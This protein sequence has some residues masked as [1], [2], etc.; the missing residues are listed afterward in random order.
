MITTAATQGRYALVG[1]AGGVSVVDLGA[2][3][4]PELIGDV[5]L[6]ASPIE[7]GATGNTVAARWFFQEFHACGA[8][9][10]I[11]DISNPTQPS[12]A[13]RID[14]PVCT[15]LASIQVISDWLYLLKNGHLEI[16]NISDPS[17]PTL[18]AEY[19]EPTWDRLLVVHEDTL[20]VDAD[21]DLQFMSL[22]DPTAPR[23]SA[24]YQASDNVDHALWIEDHLLLAAGEAF[25]VVDVSSTIPLQTALIDGIFPSG[26]ASMAAMGDHCL[27]IE[28]EPWWANESFRLIDISDLNAPSSG[29]PWIRPRKVA[30]ASGSRNRVGALTDHALWLLDLEPGGHYVEH[31]AL[32]LDGADNVN[33]QDDRALVGKGREDGSGRGF[34]SLQVLDVAAA[35]EAEVVGEIELDLGFDSDPETCLQLAGDGWVAVG[36]GRHLEGRLEI[37]DV[38]DPSDPNPGTTISLPARPSHM[39]AVDDLLYL[40]LNNEVV[41]V[42]SSHPHEAEI[43]GGFD[44]VP[45]WEYVLEIAAWGRYVYLVGRDTIYMLDASA[46]SGPSLIGQVDYSGLPDTVSVQ[47]GFL[48]AHEGDAITIIDVRTPA[49]AQLWHV[50][51]SL[52]C[53]TLGWP[54]LPGFAF[55]DVFVQAGDPCGVQTIAISECTVSESKPT[56][57][58]TVSPS[59][60]ES[61]TPVRFQDHSAGEPTAWH[62][63]FGDGANSTVAEPLHSYSDSGTYTV[64]LTVSNAYGSETSQRILAVTDPNAALEADFGWT[65]DEPS[66]RAAVQYIDTSSGQPTSWSWDF[67]DGYRSILKN[68]AHRYSVPGDYLVTL[69]VEDGTESSSVAMTLTV[70]PW[71]NETL[72][73]TV[74]PN[75]LIAAAASTP[76]RHGTQW[77]TDLTIFNPSDESGWALVHFL[78]RGDQNNYW[79]PGSHLFLHPRQTITVENAVGGLFGRDDTSG[80]LVAYTNRREVLRSRTMT[81]DPDGGT[82]GQ[83]VASRKIQRNYETVPQVVFGLR[84]DANF[85]SNVGF[86]NSYSSPREL[87]VTVHSASG[88]V[89]G[90]IPIR[91]SQYGYLQIERILREVDS[92]GVDR[93]YLTYAASTRKITAY[94]S[95]ID[96]K[97]G[98]AVFIPSEVMDPA[99]PVPTWIIPAVASVDGANG[100]RW[101]SQ[102]ELLNPSV[103]TVDVVIRFLESGRHGP[104]TRQH[105]LNLQ[106]GQMIRIDDVVEGLFGLETTGALLVQSWPPIHVTSRTFTKQAG[107]GSPDVTFGQNIYAIPFSEQ[108]STEKP[109]SLIHLREDDSYRSNLGLVNPSDDPA[110]V[111]IE[112]LNLFGLHL[113]T[114]IITL[115]PWEHRQLNRVLQFMG[116][117]DQ[118]TLTLTVQEGSIAAYASVV[119][120]STG[121]PVFM[122]ALEHP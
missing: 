11:V 103:D 83:G 58:F 15:A 66:I 93:G 64:T 104:P 61:G 97:T 113:D 121:D 3:S 18:T 70:L 30:D 68:P 21:G 99:S 6:P 94:A 119:D 1:V 2:P 112:V 29:D 106:G 109:A 13:S 42:D 10:T 114:A 111:R 98:D 40:L 51:D 79:S 31:L 17:A 74:G 26:V 39:V 84:E 88:E 108:L 72:S 23:L 41:V 28:G 115:E 56:S 50:I 102:L 69:Q 43:V 35:G 107:G 67:G 60:P 110:V 49:D 16:F 62:W 85:R 33:L 5:R 71:I 92:E 87:T 54:D 86:V 9:I 73:T 57:N 22:T 34:Y 122:T 48:F 20:I 82:F 101:Q 53:H 89:L 47:D 78:E 38:T 80:A 120:N 75:E 91:L 105:V 52:P 81:H 90:D 76:G 59:H 24:T 8:G 37:I 19:D 4:L 55:G 45:S 44:G 63:D 100:T 14:F 77:R 27:V 7:I 65:V 96:N 12:V 116:E 36:S 25:E 117:I 95:V 32:E 118:A 46:P